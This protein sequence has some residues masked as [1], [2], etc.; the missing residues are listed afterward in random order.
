MGH[1]KGWGIVAQ[2]IFFATIFQLQRNQPLVCCKI[3][4][5][6]KVVNKFF[7]TLD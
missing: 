7:D 4:L 3:L 5:Q 6:W 2:S 1:G